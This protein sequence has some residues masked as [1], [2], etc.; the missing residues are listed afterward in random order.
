M[1][2]RAAADAR[3]P[4]RRTVEA[5]RRAQQ[6]IGVFHQ[7]RIPSI[8]AGD[9]GP[10]STLQMAVWASGNR[11]AA[12]ARTGNTV[13][14]AGMVSQAA[15]TSEVVRDG[16]VLHEPGGVFVGA[17]LRHAGGIRVDHIIGLFR[18]WWIPGGMTPDQGTYVRYDHEAMV[19][20]LALEAARAG[21]MVIGEDLGTVEAGKIAGVR[22]THPERVMYPEIG[23]TKADIARYYEDIAPVMLPLRCGSTTRMTGCRL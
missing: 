4:L 17:I 20:V 21:A 23:V 22:I 15:Y 8:S 10:A 13:T 14:D 3:E 16:T 2:P 1:A 9:R 19:G 12:V 7:A 6:R 18:L 5:A 11:K